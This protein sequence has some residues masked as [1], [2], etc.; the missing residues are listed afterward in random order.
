MAAYTYT[1][2][3]EWQRGDAD[4]LDKRYS[5]RHAVR[6]DGGVELAG[7]SSPHSVPLPMSDATAVDPE[8]LFVAALS[9]CHLL[10]FLGL[11]AKAGFCVD[12][13]VD[14]ADGVMGANAAGRVAMLTVTLRP[15]VTFSGAHQPTRA[16][17]VR[18][19]DDAH[20][21]CFIANSV[22]CDVRCEPA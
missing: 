2:E 14:R 4:F 11:A 1:A 10:W 19:H 9:S 17:L 3:T 12:R 16:E 21:A 5:R 20:H 7:S 8:E 15:D 6:F 18:L 13:Y 22:T